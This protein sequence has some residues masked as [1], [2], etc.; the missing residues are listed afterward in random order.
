M[1]P[2]L[3]NLIFFYAKD[4]IPLIPTAGSSVLAPA[5]L[6]LSNFL[7]LCF[8]RNATIEATSRL[9]VRGNEF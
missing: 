2:H 6:L 5:F 1:Y 7:Y 4:F 9:T 3:D 8:R